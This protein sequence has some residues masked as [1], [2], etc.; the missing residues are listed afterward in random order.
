[1][2]AGIQSKE[3]VL[4]VAGGVLL[5]MAFLNV[6]CFGVSGCAPRT[7]RTPVQ[8]KEDV[9]YEEITKK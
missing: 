8:R 3:V 5:I 9:S 6:G 2:A 4:V 1:L 7:N